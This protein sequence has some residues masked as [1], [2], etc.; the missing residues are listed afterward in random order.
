MAWAY[1]SLFTGLEL[2]FWS[3]EFPQLLDQ[4]SIGIVLTFA[5]LGE[6]FGERRRTSSS[7]HIFM[8]A[9]LRSPQPMHAQANTSTNLHRPTP[10]TRRDG[11]QQD[12]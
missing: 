10:R 9:R 4:D 5:G 6:V 8:L 1:I 3:G 2:A 7:M 11:A 12:F